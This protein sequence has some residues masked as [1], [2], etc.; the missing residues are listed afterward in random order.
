ML[1]LLLA[2]GLLVSSTTLPHIMDL[3]EELNVDLPW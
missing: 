3:L 2:V 1:R